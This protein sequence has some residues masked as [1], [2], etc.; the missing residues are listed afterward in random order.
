MTNALLG[1]KSPEQVQVSRSLGGR[2]SLTL[3]VLEAETQA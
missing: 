2:W 1:R 3:L